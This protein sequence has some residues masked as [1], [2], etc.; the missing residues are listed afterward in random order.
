MVGDGKIPVPRLGVPI[1]FE[2]FPDLVVSW[3]HAEQP[4]PPVLTAATLHDDGSLQ[5]GEQKSQSIVRS[6]AKWPV[7]YSAMQ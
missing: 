7:L 1:L 4:G 5:P 3:L 6:D 2:G